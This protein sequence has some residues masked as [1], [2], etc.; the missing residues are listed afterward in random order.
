[1]ARAENIG[2]LVGKIEAGET[3]TPPVIHTFCDGQY[4]R[5]MQAKAGVMIVGHKHKTRHINIFIKGKIALL[6]KEGWK[7]LEAP[8]Y[9]IG[10]PKRKIAYVIE[11]MAW[12]NV[13]KTDLTD[14]K[15]LEKELYD[16][17]DLPNFEL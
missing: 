8:Q 9:F 1:M 11:D 16:T 3:Y 6:T 17:S 2:D 7:V 10:E 14:I 4:M 5:E 13:H 15:E 12:L